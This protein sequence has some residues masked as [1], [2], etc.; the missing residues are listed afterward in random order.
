[1]IGISLS[2]LF[3]YKKVTTSKKFFFF[4]TVAFSLQAFGDTFSLTPFFFNFVNKIPYLNISIEGAGAFL[5]SL[6]FTIFYLILLESLRQFS[7]KKINGQYIAIFIIGILRIIVL[8]LPANKWGTADGSMNLYYI[9][10]GLLLMEIF[11]IGVL[12]VREAAIKNIP[13]FTTIGY[14]IL[15]AWACF[16]IIVFWSSKEPLVALL[17]IP[18]TIAHVVLGIT[19]YKMFTMHDKTDYLV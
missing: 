6:I 15:F 10:N 18:K 14:T 7:E 12:Y 13:K 1:M 19:F 11:A 9:R 16:F 5:S 17:T 8:F 2:M 4:I 3:K